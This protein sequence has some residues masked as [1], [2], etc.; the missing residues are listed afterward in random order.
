M[1]FL[2]PIPQ[3]SSTLKSLTWTFCPTLSSLLDTSKSPT[4]VPESQIFEP[5]ALPSVC[6]LAGSWNQKPELGIE[7]RCCH[8]RH[9]YINH[10]ANLPPQNSFPKLRILIS[11][12]HHLTSYSLELR[13]QLSHVL[14]TSPPGSL[15][16]SLF[17]FSL[18]HFKLW[19]FSPS[20]QLCGL[21]KAKYTWLLVASLFPLLWAPALLSTPSLVLVSSPPAQWLLQYLKSTLLFFPFLLP[22]LSFTSL[23]PLHILLKI[24]ILARGTSDLFVTTPV[25]S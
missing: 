13:Y 11:H 8:G 15:K 10:W 20:P 3:R 7:P 21:A 2:L 24:L 23:Q 16:I 9:R 12:F 22:H 19:L 6:S 14:S 17:S 25:S 4:S 1:N 5:S 18:L